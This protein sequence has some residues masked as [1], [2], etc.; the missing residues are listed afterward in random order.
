MATPHCL[1]ENIK[2][3]AGFSEKLKYLEEE[4]STHQIIKQKSK[5]ESIFKR[6][7]DIPAIKVKCLQQSKRVKK[8]KNTSL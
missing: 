6:L 8:K 4:M 5:L 3:L 2:E 1:E 7:K